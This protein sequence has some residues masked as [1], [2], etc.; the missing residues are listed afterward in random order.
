M[1]VIL[2]TIVATFGIKGEVKIHSNTDFAK[3][4]Y[5]KGNII[6]AYS[7]I[8]KVSENLTVVSYKQVKNVDVV[9]FEEY[10]TPETVSKLI[11]YQLFTDATDT[12][13]A[14][15]SYHYDDLWHCEVYY[16]N[17]KIGVV[18]DMINSASSIILRIK[19]EDKK[20]LLYPFIERFITSVDVAN[21]RI[22]LNPIEGM[23]D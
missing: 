19:R 8:K 3:I 18:D 10:S 20:D 4:R 14:K 6:R 13:L 23:L 2:G 16:N 22:E 7:P 12:K 21:K 11:G 5:K 17:V 1:E 15:N 9:L